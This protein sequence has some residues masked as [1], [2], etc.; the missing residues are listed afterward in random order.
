M[1]VSLDGIGGHWLGLPGP[2]DQESPPVRKRGEREE[3]SANEEG[4]DDRPRPGVSRKGQREEDAAEPKP[5]RRD[6]DEPLP[7]R[8]DAY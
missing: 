6:Q 5:Q 4:D 8:S 7:R 3:R 2:A 1:R